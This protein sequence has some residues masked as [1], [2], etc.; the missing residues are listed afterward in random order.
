M[1]IYWLDIHA[2][3]LLEVQ[4]DLGANDPSLNGER[5][6]SLD[7]KL[8]VSPSDLQA[9]FFSKCENDYIV[10]FCSSSKVPLRVVTHPFDSNTCFEKAELLDAWDPL[11][12]I[13][14]L[15]FEYSGDGSIYVAVIPETGC[16]IDRGR[17]KEL[18]IIGG[19]GHLKKSDV[20]PKYMTFGTCS[21]FIGPWDLRMN[22]GRIEK[23]VFDAEALVFKKNENGLDDFSFGVDHRVSLQMNYW[24]CFQMLKRL[25]PGV[26]IE[27]EVL[28]LSFKEKLV[29]SN[30]KINI[31]YQFQSLNYRTAKFVNGIH[32]YGD[33][34]QINDYSDE[35]N[36][37][38][39]LNGAN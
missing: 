23:M 9:L 36:L 13:K 12:V 39:I 25:Y 29:R 38:R 28:N 15:Y 16:F 19:N 7:K 22:G 30:G 2:A 3:P 20:L 37:P 6:A 35:I 26:V 17:L 11:H 4:K 32:G 10:P 18:L 33:V 8:Q 5:A 14:A 34:T 24:S 31:T 21:P 27:E 1:S